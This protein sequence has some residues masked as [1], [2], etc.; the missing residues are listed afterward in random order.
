MVDDFKIDLPRFRDEWLTISDKNN[1][2]NVIKIEI[3]ITQ[4]TS[5]ILFKPDVQKINNSLFFS[6]CNIVSSKLTKK[7]NGINL[8]RTLGMV[9]IEYEK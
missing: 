7:T 1:W 4:F 9:K 6:N 2:N 5:L 3:I 8:C